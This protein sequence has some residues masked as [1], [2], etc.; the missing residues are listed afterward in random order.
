MGKTPRLNPYFR[1]IYRLYEA[2]YLLAILG[3]VRGP[4]STTNLDLSTLLAVRRRFQKNIAFLG[5][6]K[7]GGPSSTAVAVEDREDC[8][9]FWIASNEGSSEETR[10]FLKAVIVAAK[11]FHTMPDD[12]KTKARFDLTHKCVNFASSRINK[13]AHGLSSCARKCRA[14]ITAHMIDQHGETN[15]PFLR[16]DMMV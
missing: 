9:V 14:H 4:H 1:L 10:T 8:N 16:M 6:Y 12:Q 7:K 11:A 2:L 13:Q 15:P 5:D 3:R